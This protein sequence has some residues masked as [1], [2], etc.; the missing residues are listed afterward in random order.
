MKLSDFNP[1]QQPEKRQVLMGCIMAAAAGLC[2]LLNPGSTLPELLFFDFPIHLGIGAAICVLIMASDSLLSGHSHKKAS[3]ELAETFARFGYSAEI[4]GLLKNILPEP[5]VQEKVLRAFVLVMA[6]QEQEA[7]EQFADIPADSLPL[8]QEAMLQTARCLRLIRLGE[9]PKAVRLMEEYQDTL[10]SV[11]EQ[12]PEFGSQFC[13]YADDTLAYDMLAAAY[14]E[15]M[16]QPE[17]AAQYRIRIRE[18]AALRP[19]AEAALYDALA[20]LQ[21]LWAKGDTPAAQ[22]AEPKLTAEIGSASL[23]TGAKINLRRLAGDAKLFHPAR[24][25]AKSFMHQD[26]RL[27]EQPARPQIEGLSDL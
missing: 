10:D 23:S 18:R 1:F 25:G 5:S 2:L 27:P 12:D 9:F 8:R 19:A 17:R 6:G 11:Y 13:D 21:R 7:A 22:A 20:E 15:L 16:Q 3:P 14:S 24:L 4:A 26:R